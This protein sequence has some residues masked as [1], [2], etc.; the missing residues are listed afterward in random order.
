MKKVLLALSFAGLLVTSGLV[1]AQT[2]EAP[3]PKKD[4]VNIDTDAKPT[5]YYA[6]ED[7]KI[8]DDEKK[9]STI[10]IAI[11]VGAVVVIGG[12]AVLILRKKK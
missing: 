10:L 7:D 8:K 1:T 2:Q 9:S 5:Q 4:T 12:G 3:K 11:I 6:I